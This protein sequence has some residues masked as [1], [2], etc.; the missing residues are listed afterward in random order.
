MS[1]SEEKR[2]NIKEIPGFYYDTEKKRYFRIT[3]DHPKPAI[4]ACK[5]EVIKTEKQKQKRHSNMHC[6]ILEER[7]ICGTNI[8]KFKRNMRRSSIECI[9]FEKTKGIKLHLEEANLKDKVLIT[10]IIPSARHDVLAIVSKI[11]GFDKSML[12]IY[13]FQF[14]KE[15]KFELTS[16]YDISIAQIT[17]TVFATNTRSFTNELLISSVSESLG[18]S[19][20]LIFWVDDFLVTDRVVKMRKGHNIWSSCFVHNPCTRTR[21]ALGLTNGIL[22]VGPE[23]RT[24]QHPFIRTSKSDV[25]SL[26]GGKAPYLYSG[27]RDGYIRSFDFRAFKVASSV[28]A[29]KSVDNVKILSNQTHLIVSTMAGH[30]ELWDIRMWKAVLSYSGHANTHSRLSLH[31]DSNENF[32][33][34]VGEDCVARIWDVRTAE[35][36][37]EFPSIRFDEREDP[38]RPTVLFLD[39]D[40]NPYINSGYLYGIK[41]E[42]FYFKLNP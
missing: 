9:N 36:L 14:S 31:L 20:A 32:L 19:Q 38:I 15:M 21:F 39:Q 33:S 30:L 1:D 3:K 27:S 24:E 16:S 28:R 34:S 41:E 40:T 4:K 29:K 37:R 12:Q 22:L 7:E 6:K 11:K 5:S 13:D 35:L 2:Q 25:L 18:V 10:K 42:L 17:D 26:D 23:G 8:R